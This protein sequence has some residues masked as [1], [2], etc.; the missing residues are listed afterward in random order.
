MK[1]QIPEADRVYHRFPWRGCNRH[2]DPEEYEF[3]RVVFGVT[4][5]SFKA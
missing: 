2:G 4:S 5:S 3:S 1:I